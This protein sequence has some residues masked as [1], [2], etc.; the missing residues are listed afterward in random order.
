MVR[1]PKLSTHAQ[2]C[3]WSKA[4][5]T[6]EVTVTTTDS[7]PS[8]KISS[9]LDEKDEVSKLRSLSY[10]QPSNPLIVSGVPGLGVS[11]QLPIVISIS[12]TPERRVRW[13]WVKYLRNCHGKGYHLVKI[14][15]RIGFCTSD[16]K[17]LSSKFCKI[18]IKLQILQNNQTS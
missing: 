14:C 13:R 5:N 15:C 11:L 7:V 8:P 2:I 1:C 9:C 17:P 10:H 4:I 3:L 12:I 18:T 16:Q 6:F